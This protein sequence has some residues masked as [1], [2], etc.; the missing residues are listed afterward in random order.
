[1]YTIP[2]TVLKHG[3]RSLPNA[4]VLVIETIRRAMKVRTQNSSNNATG[5]GPDDCHKDLK[6][7]STFAG[8]RKIASFSWAEGSQ[9]KPWWTFERSADANRLSDLGKGAK[10]LIELSSE[11]VA[12]R[13]SRAPHTRSS[14]APE[15]RGSVLR[16]YAQAVDTGE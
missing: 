16:C 13:D 9:G 2:P 10:R 11:L 15:A 8:T 7:Q 12:T 4:S 1:M 5:L 14:F 6:K 3:P